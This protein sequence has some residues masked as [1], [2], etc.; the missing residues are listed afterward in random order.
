MDQH[1]VYDP[2]HPGFVL[3]RLRGHRFRMGIYVAAWGVAG[4]LST[5]VPAGL[6]AN[7]DHVMLYFLFLLAGVVFLLLAVAAQDQPVAERAAAR[8]EGWIRALQSDRKKMWIRQIPPLL[9]CSVIIDPT[10]RQHSSDV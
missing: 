2:R 6:A 4:L 9:P 3:P 7:P 10:R 5:T 8:F 1:A